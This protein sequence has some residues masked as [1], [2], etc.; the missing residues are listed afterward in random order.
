MLKGLSIRTLVAEG[1][2][3][4]DLICLSIRTLVAEGCVHKDLRC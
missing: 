2:V 3:H 1:Y 4:K